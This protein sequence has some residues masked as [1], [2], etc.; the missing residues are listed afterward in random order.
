MVKER[1]SI[2]LLLSALDSSNIPCVIAIVKGARIT[3]SVFGI[4][5]STTPLNFQL[6]DT[7]LGRNGYEIML[8][9]SVI[10]TEI[11][12]TYLGCI[13]RVTFTIQI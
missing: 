1:I 4:S 11:A 8:K 3:A 9:I 10:P 12:D 6:T 13:A 5:V 7:R 2:S